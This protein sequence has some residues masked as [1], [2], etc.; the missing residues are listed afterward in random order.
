[1]VVPYKADQIQSMLPVRHKN[2]L[3]LET[4]PVI[5]VEFLLFV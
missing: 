4:A 1:M 5:S 3:L 2:L